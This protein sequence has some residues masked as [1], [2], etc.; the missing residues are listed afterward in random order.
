[1]LPLALFGW[2]LAAQPQTASIAG[3]V[4]DRATGQ[5]VPRMVV[6]ALGSDR[7]KAGEALTDADGRYE[8]AGLRAGAYGV[9]VL[10]DE[11]RSTYLPQWY[12][13][14]GPSI[15]GVPR[16]FGIT[17]NAGDRRTDVDVA[18]MR[19][20]AIEGVVLDPEGDPIAQVEV[21]A[22][23][24]AGGVFGRQMYTDDRG[25]YRLY[26]LLPGRYRVCARP[27]NGAM[28][29]G[30]EHRMRTCYPA[31]IAEAAAS[32]VTLTSQDATGIDI[33]LQRADARSISGTVIDASGAPA[34][35]AT[36]RV[37]PADDSTGGG[38]TQLQTGSAFIMKGLTPGRYVVVAS[39]GG[40]NPEDTDPAPRAHESAYA[41]V[42][43]TAADASIA[44][45]LSRAVTVA[46]TVTFE[47]NAPKSALPRLNV[48]TA[49]SSD[50]ALA[51]NM[52]DPAL[53]WVR[54]DFTFELVDVFRMPL[55]V[56]LR[57]LPQ[58]WLLK[59][60]RYGDRDI[61]YTPTDL[62]AA[63]GSRLQLVVTDRVASPL[64]KVVNERGEETP[65]S[66]VIAM[67]AEPTAWAVPFIRYPTAPSTSAGASLG[68]M[69][70][71][72]YLFAAL[73]LE[74]F[75]LVLRDRSRLPSVAAVATKVTLEAGDKRVLTL[76]IVALP[77][78]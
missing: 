39:V 65:A 36:V 28:S 67:P 24:S 15:F 29:A 54:D 6:A 72:D 51:W 47:G 68:A 23:R 10:H 9:N 3:R 61:T 38:S 63:P 21:S 60:V 74:D 48:Q 27:S 46:G 20:L 12:G 32:D 35:R 42:D 53:A 73:P 14:D 19:A 43:V 37:L 2:L 11:H 40:S 64:I 30:P 69:L 22:L 45:T 76:R 34:D 78:R 4:T 13:E 58:G 5:P 18:L 25:A 16:R 49:V 44:L 75:G 77:G 8:I 59:S 55:Y 50:F 52:S 56:F 1:M 62:S 33:R 41:P 17:L 71:G 66:Q 26:G 57:S 7:K 31:A 70:P